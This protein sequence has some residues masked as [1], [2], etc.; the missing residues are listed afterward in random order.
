[1]YFSLFSSFPSVHLLIPKNEIKLMMLLISERKPQEPATMF[2]MQRHSHECI[3]MNAFSNMHS[4]TEPFS[5]KKVILLS[6]AS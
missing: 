5:R 1:M 6:T 4:Q 3:L 2:A